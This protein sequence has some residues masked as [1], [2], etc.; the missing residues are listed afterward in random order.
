MPHHPLP[1]RNPGSSIP[2]GHHARH[3]RRDDTEPDGT[4]GDTTGEARA[5][6]ENP[7]HDEQSPD[8]R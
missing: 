5:P 7:T 3:L 4:S 2:A 8:D 6:V 1:R